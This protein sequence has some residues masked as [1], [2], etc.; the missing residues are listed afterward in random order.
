[1]GQTQ[2]GFQPHLLNEI[3]NCLPTQRRFPRQLDLRLEVPTL[4]RTVHFAEFSS[5][6]EAAKGS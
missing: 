1:M 4:R 6:S 2:H 5:G 3:W